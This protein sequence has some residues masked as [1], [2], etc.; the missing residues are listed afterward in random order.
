MKEVNGL[1]ASH[2][3]E[4]VKHPRVTIAISFDSADTDIVYVTSH[5]DGIGPAGELVIQGVIEKNSLS[6]QTQ[7]IDVQTA[8]STI[9]KL[10]F[11][12]VDRGGQI[13][14]LLGDKELLGFGL[15][16]KQVAVYSGYKNDPWEAYELDTTGIVENIDQ[17]EKLF[18]FSATDV[19]R[20][21]RTKI[22][23]VT[24]QYLRAGIA[25]NQKTCQLTATN[26]TAI[27]NTITLTAGTYT[28]LDLVPGSTIDVTGSVSNNGAFT[29]AEVISETEIKV[30][31]PLVT[32]AVVATVDHVFRILLTGSDL[33]NYQGVEHDAEYDAWPND[34]VA[35]V[36]IDGEIFLHDGPVND[37]NFGYCLEVRENGRGVLNT[38]TKSHNY[39]SGAK[40]EAQPEVKEV[41]YLEG[42]APKLALALLTGTLYGQTGS[43]PD[44]WNCGV[45]PK[46]VRTSEFVNIGVDLWDP[47]T[48]KGRKLQFIT[49]KEVSGK[50]FIEKQ[51]MLWLGTVMI[52]HA[53][54][55]LGLKKIPAMNSQTGFT[56]VLDDSVSYKRDV[57]KRP[58]AKLLN[59]VAINWGKIALKD[60]YT[61]TS[62]LVDATSIAVHGLNAPKTFNFEGVRLGVHTDENIRDY[63][64]VWRDLYSSPPYELTVTV[65]H[66]M[67]RVEVGDSVR[68]V[69]P[70]HVDV[71]KKTP[72]D[73]VMMVTS[74]AYNS[75]NGD[76]RL[77]LIGPSS[78]PT[79]LA[80]VSASAKLGAGYYSPGG[81]A[82]ELGAAVVAGG[83]TIVGG[84]ITGNCILAGDDS[85]NALSSVFYYN[86]DLEIGSGVVVSLF[87]NVNFRIDGN[88]TVNGNINSLG[89]PNLG[90]LYDGSTHPITG[91]AGSTIT[92]SEPLD[93]INIGDLVTANITNY[94][95][96]GEPPV[97]RYFLVA[98]KPTANSITV[99]FP[100]GG[101]V[102]ASAS[103]LYRVEPYY[104]PANIQSDVIGD[105]AFGT[106]IGLAGA[107]LTVFS[108]S[109]MRV[110]SS[111][112]GRT[113]SESGGIGDFSRHLSIVNEGSEIVGLPDKFTGT[114]GTG[115]YP[116]TSYIS[117]DYYATHNKILASGG[118]GGAGG[119]GLLVVCKGSS[120][121]VNSNIDLSGETGLVPDVY[122]ASNY[123]L[124]ISVNIYAGAGRG[125]NPGALYIMH[126]GDYTTPSLELY[127]TS[128]QGSSPSLGTGVNSTSPVPMVNGA[129]YRSLD[130]PYWDTYIYTS[131]DAQFQYIP[132]SEV[133]VGEPVEIAE[134]A[135][136]LGLVEVLN[137]PKSA[138]GNLSSI[139]VTVTAPSDTAYDYANVYYRKAG[140]TQWS[141]L[142]P[143]AGAAVEVVQ[144]VVSDGLTWEYQARAVSQLGVEDQ[145]GIV[146]SITVTDIVTAP[147]AD[148]VLPI[149]LPLDTPG[150]LALLGGGAEFTGKSC[151][152]TWGYNAA[153][154]T[155]P[156]HFL[157]YQVEVYNAFGG[158]TLQRTLFTI[159][160]WLE[161]TE[162]M[163]TEDG[164]PYRE[165]R[166]DIT[167]I[168][169]QG[170]T[171]ATATA[172][173]T[174]PQAGAPA[175][176]TL[177]GVLSA[178][179]LDITLPVES[180]LAGI[181]VYIS[182]TP[183]F[184][185]DANT[186]V[187]DGQSTSLYLTQWASGGVLADVAA[188]TTYYVRYGL[189]DS[190]DKTGVTLSAEQ[191]VV[192]AAISGAVDANDIT[193]L[194]E[195]ATRITDV[196]A[197]F[198]AANMLA[199]A[200]TS[201]QIASIVAGKIATGTLSSTMTVSGLITTAA[202]G[203]R[204]EMG[205]VID[206]GTYVLRYHDG[207][208]DTRF[209]IDQ[210]GNVVVNGS[211]TVTNP[212][213]V[214]TTLNVADG[215][216]AGATWGVDIGG[217]N[218]PAN[219]ADV[220]Q[221][222][223][224]AGTT[225]TGGGITL[226]GGGAINAG[227]LTA[228]STTK[229]FWL[230]W[231]GVANYDFHIGDANNYLR[232]DGS[233]NS[234]SIRGSLIASSLATSTT[235]RRTEIN[236]ASSNEIQFYDDLGAGVVLA[237]T[238][239]LDFYDGDH[240]IITAGNL[241][242]GTA[243]VGVRGVT[244]S[245]TGVLGRASSGAGVQGFS[246]TGYAVAG[247]GG[248]VTGAGVYGQ[249]T[250]GPGVKGHCLGTKNG[251]YFS[252][253]SGHGLYGFSLAADKFAV[254]GQ[255]ADGYGGYFDAGTGPAQIVLLPSTSSA[256]PVHVA[257]K[258][259][260][261]MT[262]LGWVYSNTNGSTAWTRIG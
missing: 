98:D 111:G 167:S 259:S 2:L 227:K 6:N 214:R 100:D 175:A 141:F 148:P 196:D 156:Q 77:S 222:S 215:S 198:I 34:T 152:I 119:A 21:A 81:A 134:R 38:A 69:M 244:G 247:E 165:L 182:N 25:A 132:A 124:S 29:I 176:A 118:R 240:A 228:A 48:D 88:F 16:Y 199:D 203:W 151:H 186:L 237:A 162:Q 206:G 183:G 11:N 43:L 174:N 85:M 158:D 250:D 187:F 159:N 9:G 87:N 154:D 205:P 5:E 253:V 163:A 40:A 65:M 217:S 202:S 143:A 35:L 33:T 89:S 188:G 66:K 15:R 75:I 19:H 50:D 131:E 160:P 149:A 103:I 161:Y 211:I 31:E 201:T 52:I 71:I 126:D 108:N 123:S 13:S 208:G 245:G 153:N 24:T 12:L 20:L 146:A 97:G 4:P 78:S 120:F 47:A 221:T 145:D 94:Y 180:D 1:Y 36:T 30:N 166:F 127:V 18:K 82:R 157:H 68:V 218:L 155:T 83:G 44:N 22:F 179:Q 171:G 251:G 212:G 184:T 37:P 128:Q 191:S 257:L 42:A 193:G 213:D 110:A 224:I 142:A 236:V 194:G 93:S 144:V 192:P 76:V 239:G 262:S 260:L 209:S 255:A 63:L 7:K 23:S 246:Y 234:L 105:S 137:T 129:S 58:M 86:G 231:D 46:F 80:A 204:V 223:L 109:T 60:E 106:N 226:S 125:G 133:P 116:V 136:S 59:N 115:G 235:G 70:N 64:R 107:S 56:A 173:F 138:E 229:G 216:T 95:Q 72:F 172:T 207:L 114:G 73:R 169:R 10:S 57:L 55:S 32:E 84:V 219:N 170:H 261:W 241:L 61:K 190:F 225:I 27:V 139:E 90:G 168:A 130:R 92:S 135:A 233:A 14:D 79:P 101:S 122:T 249:N 258:G 102:E 49:T 99:T 96:T 181:L 189:Y 113:E 17:E 67:L 74:A 91:V 112:Y 238:V 178:I 150:N 28:G 53:D 121:G 248:G 140:E 185:A 210:L 242:A 3:D 164:G 232:W 39:D 197:A 41:V 45:P 147:P 51:I 195:W 252:S 230:G 54:G 220:T 200:I 117:G 26:F 8:T 177:R 243:T 256:T 254:V 104:T 62:Q